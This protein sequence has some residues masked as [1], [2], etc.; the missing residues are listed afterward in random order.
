MQL[1]VDERHGVGPVHGRHRPG[2]SGFGRGLAA[3]REGG[4]SLGVGDDSAL[5]CRDGFTCFGTVVVGDYW[6]EAGY[7]Q[8]QTFGEETDDLVGAQLGR[9][10]DVVR[11]L[12]PRLPWVAPDVAQR[13]AVTG[14][15]ATLALGTPLGTVFGIPSLDGSW[16][17]TSP[18]GRNPLVAVSSDEYGCQATGSTEAYTDQLVYTEVEVHVAAGA[19]WGFEQFREYALT[20]RG[21]VDD[22]TTLEVPG[23]E[24]ALL[25][26]AAMSSICYLDVLVDDSWMRIIYKGPA[27]TDQRSRLVEVAANVIA[28]R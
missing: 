21:A 23:A 22:V 15:C 3:N 19:G 20:G 4:G 6:I 10:A 14:D 13:W 7:T 17:E 11:P 28:A 18:D 27:S 5:A 8:S 1:D 25:Q 26:C 24:D 2:R 9:L 16:T 12:E